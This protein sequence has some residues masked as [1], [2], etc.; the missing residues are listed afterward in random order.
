MK[1]AILKVPQNIAQLP[2]EIADIANPE[3]IAGYVLLKVRAC[4]VCRTDLHIVEGEMLPIRAAEH[5]GNSIMPTP[6]GNVNGLK[7]RKKILPSSASPANRLITT[8]LGSCD[9]RE[10]TTS[11]VWPRLGD[12]AHP[13]YCADTALSAEIRAILKQVAQELEQSER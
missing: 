3:P 11:G 13:E 6:W 12:A 5:M 8:P 2:L 1:A 4:G 10:A 9:R 7:P